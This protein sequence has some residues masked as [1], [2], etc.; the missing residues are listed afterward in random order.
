MKILAIH[1]APPE[2]NAGEARLAGTH[3]YDNQVGVS[4]AGSTLD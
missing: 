3:A 4:G 2:E 1:V